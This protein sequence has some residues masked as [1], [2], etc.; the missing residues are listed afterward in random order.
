MKQSFKSF[1][2]VACL[3]VLSAAGCGKREGWRKDT[4]GYTRNAEVLIFSA[5]WCT[6]CN[7]EIPEVHYLLNADAQDL[8]KHIK[9]TIHV[10]SDIDKRPPNAT[11][12]EEYQRILY[13]TEGVDFGMAADPW[14]Y[15]TYRQYFK[16]TGGGVPG[17]VILDSNRAVVKKFEPGSD[18]DAHDIFEAMKS[19]VSEPEARE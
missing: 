9:V 13:E 4:L 18:F 2:V 19:A 16:W 14:M 12:V 8:N 11:A 7:H 1:W 15:K 10:V 6:V 5:P 17:A 3:V